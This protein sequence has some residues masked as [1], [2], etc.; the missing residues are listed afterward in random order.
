M[1]EWVAMRPV[2]TAQGHRHRA[3]WR[4]SGGLGSYGQGLRINKER[5][6]GIKGLCEVVDDVV[7]VFYTNA[8]TYGRRRDVLLRE[9]FGRHL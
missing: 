6:D 1:K 8:Q 9:F 2:S 7:D 3:E 5:S 4:G